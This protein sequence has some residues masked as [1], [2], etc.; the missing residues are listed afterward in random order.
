MQGHSDWVTSVSFNPDGSVLASGSD[1]KTIIL[2]SMP[3]GQLI[4]TLT[5]SHGDTRVMRVCVCMC[6]CACVCVCVCVCVRACV[7]VCVYVCVCMCVS[8]CM[9]VCAS[10][11]V[12]VCVC[13]SV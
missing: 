4:K 9:C 11:Y 12:C 6:V 1:D 5:V 2:W 13:A 8:V 7:C 3:D 10:V